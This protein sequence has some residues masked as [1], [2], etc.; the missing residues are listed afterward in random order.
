LTDQERLQAELIQAQKMEAT[1]QLVSGVA[2]ELNNPLASILGFSQL[3]RRDAALPEDLR[4]NADLLVEE[5]TRTRR[6]VQNLLDFARQRPPERH[7]TTIR[8]LVDS[9]L[10]LQSYSLGS[11]LIDLDVDI[12]A[13][14]PPVELDRG[15]LQQVLVNLTHNAIYSIRHG[16]GHR[17][18]IL[19]ALDAD[20]EGD[21][22]RVTVMDDGPG[23]PPEHVDRLF[24][25]FFTTKPPSE[26]T[27][28]GL[29]VSYGIIASHGGE[30]RYVPSGF[31]RGAA[32]TFDL[33]V[34]AVRVD[35]PPMPSTPPPRSP[36]VATPHV[37]L[38]ASP[39]PAADT[40]SGPA[41]PTRPDDVPAGATDVPRVLILDDEPSI[42]IFLT[43]ALSSLGYEGVPTGTAREAIDRARDG[44][45]A[46]FLI[47]H[48]M[49]GLS[50]IDVYEAVVA[51]RPDYAGR[52]VMM[53]GDILNATLERF[54]SVTGVGLLAKP[55]DLDTLDQTVRDL[56]DGQPRG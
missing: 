6:I 5:A 39:A 50:G 45:Y 38:A 33:P 14:L 53:S 23:V 15:Q 18:R 35:Q 26:G 12:E 42:R 2:H 40:P 51:E 52:F 49:A 27:G 21:R 54:A 48:Q 24:E 19:A 17:V 4:H 22:V 13:D 32:F 55:F 25:A 43:K 29:P 1:G 31:E 11:G 46:A 47:D 56:I 28:L 37:A 20:P 34:R 3:I 30:L 41:I 44:E 9:V 10:A 36:A 8:A 16:G 7:P